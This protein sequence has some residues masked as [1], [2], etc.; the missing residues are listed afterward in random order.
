LNHYFSS[1]KVVDLDSCETILNINRP[2]TNYIS[3][4]PSATFLILW[5]QFYGNFSKIKYTLSNCFNKNP[6]L[7]VV[8]KNETENDVN[9]LS[10]YHIP[11]GKFVKGFQ[12]KKQL[13]K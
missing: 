11:S 7:F 2:R 3:F 6:P 12:Q 5:E 10:V 13:E 8:N 4:S 9:N 1:V